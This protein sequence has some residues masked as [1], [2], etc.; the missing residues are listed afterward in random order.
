MKKYII[1]ILAIFLCGLTLN[2][3]E[4]KKVIG[5]V[6]NGYNYWLYTPDGAEEDEIGKPLVVFLHG[7]S[8][9]GTD[10]EKVEKY[11]TLSALV[12]GRDI[13][14]YVI[15]PQSPKGAWV[16]EKVWNVIDNVLDECNVDTTRIYVLGMSLGGYGT[17]DVAGSYPDRIA[18]AIAMGGGSTLRDMSGLAKVPLWIIHGTGDDLV[19]VSCSDKVYDA[20][21]TALTDE[22]EDRLVYDRITGMNHSKP[23]RLFYHPE[24]YEWLFQHSLTDPGRPIVEPMELTEE[25]FGN[26]Y[27]GIN[28]KK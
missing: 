18:A 28:W 23:A 27:Q 19:P 2:A 7:K 8:L 10:M 4:I 6:N 17:L 24:I 26:C 9:S 15:A 25:F 3:R 21:R 11:G 16:P 20:I 1:Y 14:A 12:K 22:D 13:D 5:K